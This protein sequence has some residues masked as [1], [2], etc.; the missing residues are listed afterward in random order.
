MDAKIQDLCEAALSR[1]ATIASESG[2]VERG[3][4]APFPD[5]RAFA[6]SLRLC[7]DF[8]SA[9]KIVEKHRVGASGFL[10]VARA[11]VGYLKAGVCSLA[12][13]P[14]VS[15][16]PYFYLCD[17]VIEFVDETWNVLREQGKCT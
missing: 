5:I 14:D 2:V 13:Q 10:F 1:L 15:V 12:E 3:Q 17:G 6:E 7:P 4:D 16:G 8:A 9:A 11:F